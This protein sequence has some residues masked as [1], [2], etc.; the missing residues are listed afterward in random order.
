MGQQTQGI[1]GTVT[2]G[3]IDALLSTTMYT[4]WNIN[5]DSGV[6]GWVADNSLEEVVTTTLL[7]DINGDG[8]V[9]S[10]D[11]SIMNSKWLLA[12][13]LSDL[14]SDGI[15]NSIDFSIMNNNWLKTN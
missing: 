6:D 4:W 8:I 1:Q 5:F 13:T 2:A 3:P 11:W 12:D 14:N 7:G 9:N 10:V 15:V